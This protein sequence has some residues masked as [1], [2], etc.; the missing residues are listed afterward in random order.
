MNSS[1][2]DFP[3]ATLNPSRRNF[4]KQSGFALAGAFGAGSLANLLLPS[5]PAHAA[6]YKALV[7]VFLY[8]GNDGLNTVVPIDDARYTEYSTVRKHLALPRS[9]LLA[10][11]GT[12]YA[13]HPALA[14]LHPAWG[15][16]QLAALFNVGPLV[17]PITKAELLAAGENSPLLPDKLFSHTDQ[18]VLW[19]TASND[20]L[21]RAGW[22]GRAADM[23]ATR[24]PVISVGGNARYGLSSLQSPLV[25]PEPGSLFGAHE[26]SNEPWRRSD[27]GASARAAALRAL[28]VQAQDNDLGEA[29]ARQQRE[30]F[31][32]SDRLGAL[33]Q[34]LP[35]EPNAAAAID[36][37]FAPLIE[38][39]QLR[40][41]LAAQL[42]QVAKLIAGN[43]TV[44]GNRQ[45]FFAQLGGFDTHAHQI[46]TY[47]TTGKH[48]QLLEQ[49]AGALAAFH[50][51]MKNLGMSEAVTTFTQSDFGR[52]FLPNN[53]NGSDHAWGNLQLMLGG[54][55]KGGAT[56]G[57]Y[58]ELVLGGKDDVG[59]DDWELQ[60]RFIPSTSVDQY[61]AAL[62]G[63][64]GADEAQLDAIL[65]N[66]KNFGSNRRLGFL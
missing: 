10:M 43:A 30:A 41:E 34:T 11:A 40:T 26:L 45:I 38:D 64:F 19:E 57:T 47:A 2:R 22:G 15:E 8:G 32:A 42:Y 54:A 33:V 37:A 13:M 58:P 16:G 7:C 21:A 55:V 9:S 66:L 4:L 63:W 6:D 17:A 61:A 23:L 18:Q 53:S 62:L 24:N 12:D 59:V 44:Q 39:G 20:S 5:R 36:A 50:A 1:R 52:T 51:G 35:G 29:A 65:P 3:S 46:D 14:A 28:Y 56:Y 27:A 49:L 31:S 48:A 60:G 25:L